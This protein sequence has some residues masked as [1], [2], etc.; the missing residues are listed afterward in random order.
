VENLP[1]SHSVHEVRCVSVWYRPAVQSSQRL[2]P[3]SACDVPLGQAVQLRAP[4]PD[5]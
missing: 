5:W 4:T 3:D 2:A 1:S